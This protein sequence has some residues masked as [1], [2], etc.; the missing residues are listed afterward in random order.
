MVIYVFNEPSYFAARIYNISGFPEGW[1]P[2][3]PTC[4]VFGHLGFKFITEQL[5]ACLFC[6]THDNENFIQKPAVDAG[7]IGTLLTWKNAG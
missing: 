1:E 7:N 2:A 3:K 5:E 4:R 6:W